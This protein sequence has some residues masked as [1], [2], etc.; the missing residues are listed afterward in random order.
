[1]I[2]RNVLWNDLISP[3]I[4]GAMGG[5]QNVPIEICDANKLWNGFDDGIDGWNSNLSNISDRHAPRH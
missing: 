5:E 4:C 1:M 3:L 2:V